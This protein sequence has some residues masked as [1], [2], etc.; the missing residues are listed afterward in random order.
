[1]RLTSTNLGSL[2][3]LTMISPLYEHSVPKQNKQKYLPAISP[4]DS[5][6]FSVGTSGKTGTL[7]DSSD[8]TRSSNSCNTA[9]SSSLVSATSPPSPPESKAV[10]SYQ[11]NHRI[12]I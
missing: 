1:L 11:I 3:T 4:P 5:G 6:N 9:S 2:V 10:I 7:L 8:F 12:T